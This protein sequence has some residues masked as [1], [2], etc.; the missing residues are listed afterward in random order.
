MS[1]TV[2]ATG[3]EIDLHILVFFQ[4]Y[5]L[6]DYTSGDKS[7]QKLLLS[8]RDWDTLATEYDN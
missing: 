6:I 4:S 2:T 7:R 5:I 1:S 3:K 8:S